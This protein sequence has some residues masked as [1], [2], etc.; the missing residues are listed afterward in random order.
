MV[1]FGFGVGGMIQSMEVEVGLK[2]LVATATVDGES[3]MRE[4]GE[5]FETNGHQVDWPVKE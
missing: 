1:G 3:W 4:C 5:C 2:W